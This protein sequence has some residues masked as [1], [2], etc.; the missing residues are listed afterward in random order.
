MK[1]WRDIPGYEGLYKVSNFGEVYSSYKKKLLTPVKNSGYHS[2]NLHKNKSGK[3]IKAHRIVMEAFKGKSSLT[4]NHINGVKTDNR[5]E[6][7]EYCSHR[8]NLLHAFRLGLKCCKGENNS[9]NKLVEEDVHCIHSLLKQGMLQKDIAKKF[10]VS[11]PT[12]S[13]IKRGHTWRHLGN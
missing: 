2:F 12:I 8:D 4:I 1:E 7:L 3:I 13:D 5:L 10:N 9:Q 11:V 6:N